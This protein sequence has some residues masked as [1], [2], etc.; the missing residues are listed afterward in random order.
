[1]TARDKRFFLALLVAFAGYSFTA[2]LGNSQGTFAFGVLLIAIGLFGLFDSFTHSNK[3][4]DKG[5]SKHGKK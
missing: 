1:M 2:S 3:L 4:K 5:E